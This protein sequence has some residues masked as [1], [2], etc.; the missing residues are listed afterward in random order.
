M[1]RSITPGKTSRLTP[2]PE[3]AWTVVARTTGNESEQA[4]QALETICGD[5]WQPV[6]SFLRKSGHARADAEDMTQS[7]L[8][9]VAHGN[10]LRNASP[11]KGRLRSFLLGALKRFLSREFQRANAAKRGGGATF[12]FLDADEAE[13]E[14]QS[15]LR[16]EA[17]PEALYDRTWAL[18]IVASA[19][20]ALEAEFTKKGKAKIYDALREFLD[21]N[22]ASASYEKAAERLDM[23][24]TNIRTNIY[25]L[26]G[27]FRELLQKEIADTVLEPQQVDEELEHLVQILQTS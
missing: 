23:S 11:E 19:Q 6:Y 17:T 9:N 27:R 26:R 15:G 2:F 13:H 7:F 24:R 16:T 20:R 5:Y 14:F 3:T 18:Q 21:W 22:A 4:E 10:L 12:V 25:R 8:E 1:N